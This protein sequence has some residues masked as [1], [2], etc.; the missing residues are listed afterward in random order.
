MKEEQSK[1]LSINKGVEQPSSLNTQAVKNMQIRKA[2][3]IPIETYMEGILKGDRT[4]LGRAITLIES[5]LPEHQILAQQII[6]NCLPHSGKSIRVGITGVPGVGK[7]TFIEALGSKLLKQKLKVAVLA[8]DPSSER[9]KGSILGDKTRMQILSTDPSAFIRPSPSAGTLGGVARKTRESIIVCEAAGY[10]TIFIET[11]GVG[12]SETAVH[13]MVDLFLLL[14][15]PGAGDELQGI[16]RGIM[17]ISDLIVINKADDNRL[18]KVQLSQRDL[19]NALHL[20]PPAASGWQTEVEYCSSK[21]SD[22]VDLVW[23]KANNFIDFIKSNSYFEKR[24]QEQA[25]YWFHETI[26]AEIKS[27]FKNNAELNEQLRHLE[28]KVLNNEVSP[29]IAAREIMNSFMK[30]KRA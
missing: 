7:S 16:K 10:N 6:E 26:Q 3:Q 2:E 14:M 12:Q 21:N 25:G 18:D 1:G 17:E 29:F 11:V 24:R 20:F 28:T 13:S 5:T 30:S 8:V 22:R 9:T 15:L 27:L 23:D 4:I 19:I